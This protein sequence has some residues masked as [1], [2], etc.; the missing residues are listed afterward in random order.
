[1][2]KIIE[3][4]GEMSRENE[5]KTEFHWNRKP[6]IDEAAILQMPVEAN[7]KLSKISFVIVIAPGNLRAHVGF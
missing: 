5:I 3:H 2:L 6:A 1:M 4:T 7:G